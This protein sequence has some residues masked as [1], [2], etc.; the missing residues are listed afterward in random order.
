MIQQ[1]L[2]DFSAFSL[3]AIN[4]VDKKGQIRQHPL[5]FIPSPLSRKIYSP[6]IEVVQSARFVLKQL[7]PELAVERCRRHFS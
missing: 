4:V 6:P 3:I 2:I 7:D 5:L 1:V